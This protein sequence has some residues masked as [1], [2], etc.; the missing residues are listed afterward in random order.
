MCMLG[1]MGL[2]GR[3]K[4]GRLWAFS[5]L[6]SEDVKEVSYTR[7]MWMKA[8]LPHHLLSQ[9]SGAESGHGARPEAISDMLFCMLASVQFGAGMRLGW[10]SDNLF[11]R[12]PPLHA[13][14]IPCDAIRLNSTHGEGNKN[15]G[16]I[17]LVHMGGINSIFRWVKFSDLSLLLA[18]FQV[19]WPTYLAFFLPSLQNHMPQLSWSGVFTSFGERRIKRLNE[20]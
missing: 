7:A 20:L 8:T 3:W 13:Q 9:W 4:A 5:F 17:C 1:S 18:V 16:Y 11:I 14:N 10:V 15:Y 12:T 2:A 6:C 19:R